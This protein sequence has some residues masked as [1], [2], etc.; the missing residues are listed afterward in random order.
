MPPKSGKLFKARSV[1]SPEEVYSKLDGYMTSDKFETELTNIN[2]VTNIEDLQIHQDGVDGVFRYDYVATL[3]NRNGVTEVPVTQDCPFRILWDE[4]D[5]ALAWILVLVKKSNANRVAVSLGS[6]LNADV[7]EA[8]IYSADMNAY[9][10]RN[11]K[12]KIVLFDNM[13]LPGVNKN[14]IYGEELV[15]TTL[16]NEMSEHG[17]PKWIVTESELHGY[18]VGLGGDVGVTIY[19]NVENLEY[20]NFV[21]KEILPLVK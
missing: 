7:R 9:I 20:I 19:N 2:L 3:I 17:T 10:T 16:F 14:T 1:G 18:T 15:Q 13:D 11:F 5:K 6:I 8:D 21:V 4:H 12:T